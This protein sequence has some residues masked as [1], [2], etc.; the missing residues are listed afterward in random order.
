MSIILSFPPSFLLGFFVEVITWQFLASYS[1]LHPAS[2]NCLMDMIDECARSGSTW[3]ICAMTA[4]WGTS[5]RKVCADDI[6]KPSGRVMCSGFVVTCL[7][8]IGAFERRKCPVIPESKIPWLVEVWISLYSTLLQ[9]SVVQL[10]CST[11]LSLSSIS[12]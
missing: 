6:V 12:L 11:I 3:E 1:P 4:R 9:T 2:Q 7:Y 8:I 5:R 10:E